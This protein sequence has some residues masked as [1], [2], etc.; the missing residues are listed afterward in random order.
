MDN[1]SSERDKRLMRREQLK[2]EIEN[3]ER[4]IQKRTKL[5]SIKQRDK[6]IEE[7]QLAELQK[8]RM[9]VVEMRHKARQEKE[10]LQKRKCEEIR[11]K[12]EDKEIERLKEKRRQLERQIIEIEEFDALEDADGSMEQEGACGYDTQFKDINTDEYKRDDVRYKDNAKMSRSIITV[13]EYGHIDD[14]SSISMGIRYHESELERSE[15]CSESTT[16]TVDKELKWL[17]SKAKK[18]V[19]TDRGDRLKV[20]RNYNVDKCDDELLNIDV[21]HEYHNYRGNRKLKMSHRKKHG[22]V[23]QIHRLNSEA[24]IKKEGDTYVTDDDDTYSDDEY[25]IKSE[26]VQQLKKEIEDM[27]QREIQMMDEI[28][29]RNEAEKL[30]AAKRK[31]KQQQIRRLLQQ[32]QELEE[33]LLEKQSTLSSLE[34][35]YCADDLDTT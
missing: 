34:G 13:D 25:S 28:E 9:R 1:P 8:Q 33:S 12:R 4:Q 27:K 24:R 29:S 11:I 26:V 7:E 3:K 35:E 17:D 20:Q 18:H 21:N 23:D 16:D 19:V 31:L 32:K 30:K 15:T 10:D 14:I 22:N 5:A 2:L 6:E